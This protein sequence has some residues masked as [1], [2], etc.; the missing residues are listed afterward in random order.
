MD[1]ANH[2]DGILKK[3]YFLSFIK[4]WDW[5]LIVILCKFWQWFVSLQIFFRN[6]C[7]SSWSIYFWCAFTCT[8]PWL[9]CIGPNNICLDQVMFSCSI[10][11]HIFSVSNYFSRKMTEKESMLVLCSWNIIWTFQEGWK[12]PRKRF[13]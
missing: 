1:T 4:I 7:R 8:F 5:F 13:H 2:F 3:S 6:N 12:K 10:L 9:V 11:V